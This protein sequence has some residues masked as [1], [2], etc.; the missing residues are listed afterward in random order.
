MK[1]NAGKSKVM[2]F[3]RA[4]EQTINFAQPY[5][6]GWRLYLDVKYRWGRRKM[7]ELNEFKY[8]G[9]MLCKQNYK[10]LTDTF[11]KRFALR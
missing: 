1:R 9:T 8:L 2:V 11:I 6:G 4:R 5:R 7:E 10:H 3:K